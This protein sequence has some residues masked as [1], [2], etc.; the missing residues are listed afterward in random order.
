MSQNTILK[1]KLIDFFDS[2]T[3]FSKRL[4]SWKANTKF[5]NPAKGKTLKNFVKNLKSKKGIDYVFVW[6]ALSGYWG[7]VSTDVRDDMYSA[8]SKKTP[9]PIYPVVMP[10]PLKQAKSTLSRF[11]SRFFGSERGGSV[12]TATAAGGIIGD[13][14]TRIPLISQPA[15]SIKTI[16]DDVS[17]TGLFK[18]GLLQLSQRI[19][20]L[21]NTSNPSVA[22][23]RSYSRPTPHLLLV[24]PALAWDPSALLGVGKHTYIHV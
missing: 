15:I 23:K 5:E 22:I 10:L 2:Q 20:S 17:K 1:E 11:L 18:G 3:D 21:T 13:S 16:Y 24:E 9:T 7:G 6:H 12:A 14:T 19:L 4:T 8:L